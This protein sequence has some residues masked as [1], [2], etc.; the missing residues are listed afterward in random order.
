[1][2]EFEQHDSTWNDRLQDL[3]D[4]DVDASERA[5]V[6]SHLAACAHCRTQYAH[7]KR[8]D[9]AL[10]AGLAVPE[11]GASFDHQVLARIDAMDAQARDQA[12][13]QA[14]REFQ[15]SLQALARSWRRGLAFVLGGSVAGIALAFAFTA[16][17]DAAD[18]AERLLGITGRIAFV[19]TDTLHTLVTALIGAG[20]GAGISKWLAATLD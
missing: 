16:W 10:A 13:R 15:Q 17:A 2:N 1:M 7:F 19:P 12:R 5:A 11:L 20:I 4:G 18:V 3:L 9:S 14:D 6:E 8:L